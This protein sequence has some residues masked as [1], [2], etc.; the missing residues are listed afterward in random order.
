M[1]TVYDWFASRFGKLTYSMEGSR[2][3]IDGTAD[4]SGSITQAVHDSTGVD[5]DYLYST[6][7][8][9]E[10][11]ARAGYKRADNANTATTDVRD[12]DIILLSAGANMALSGG[13]GGHTGVIKSGN[14]VSTSWDTLG[15][16]GTAVSSLLF[17]DNYLIN[18][19]IQYWEI[20][21]KQET[22]QPPKAPQPPQKPANN[23]AIDQFKQAGN[24]FTA[25]GT[26]KADEIKEVNGI[27]QVVN[28]NLAGGHDFD[29]TNNGIPLE[30]LDNK[31]RGNRQDTQ[32]GDNL[33]FQSDYASGTIDEYDL[34]SCG[35]GI[36]YGDFGM[37][38]FNAEQFI[39][40]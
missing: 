5:Y 1:T 31:T 10:Y 40:L 4:C 3:G 21:R 16:T 17:N 9:S 35:I 14:L 23:T 25:F 12:E 15:A 22:N 26:F 7:T 32:I 20:W 2:N 33:A 11:L 13:A 24:E 29:W 34:A 28:Y 19:G 18:H 8:L 36:T 30:I 27:W 38:W 6:V 39:K 37:V